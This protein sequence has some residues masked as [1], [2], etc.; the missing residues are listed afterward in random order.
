MSTNATI[1]IT[2]FDNIDYLKM[3]VIDNKK[4]EKL[5]YDAYKDVLDF[6]DI[7]LDLVRKDTLINVSLYS[8]Y[9]LKDGVKYKILHMLTRDAS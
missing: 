2:P 5:T 4:V 3:S 8:D 9:F 1:T 6:Q 7:G